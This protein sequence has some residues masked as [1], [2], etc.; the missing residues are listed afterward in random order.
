MTE[1]TDTAPL[2][3]ELEV[4]AAPKPV[5]NVLMQMKEHRPAL[6]R[7][8]GSEAAMEKFETE[9][10]TQLKNAPGL[11]ECHPTSI[12][13]GYRLA[14]QL[15]LSF[16]PQGLAYLVPFG[17]QNGKWAQFVIG[18]RGF[19]ELAFRSGQV[20]DVTAALVHDGDEFDYQY[21]TQP[22]LVHKP[23]GPAGERDI[24]AAYAVARLKTGGA[25]FRVIYE[26]DWE[27][28]RM[29]SQLGAR[30]KGPWLDHRPAM[31][32]KTA[33][34]RLEP[35][36]PKTAVLAQAVEADEQPAPDV[37]DLEVIEA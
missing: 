18:Y 33:F 24:I 5:Q 9:L 35:M 1:T 8:L 6:V 4:A 37:D 28:A 7:L 29:A 15:G 27:K 30:N 13:G 16:G 22:R 21:G 34:R 12:I 25:P 10:V 2:R 32:L 23:E 19:V 31:I 26:E 20:K 11:L 14:A 3:A 36:L 17:G